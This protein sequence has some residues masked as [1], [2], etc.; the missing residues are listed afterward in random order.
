ME[1]LFS[2]DLLSIWLSWK[3]LIKM[4]VFLL[5][6]AADSF[7][8]IFSHLV[9]SQ[10]EEEEDQVMTRPP[11]CSP[12][13]CPHRS[14]SPRSHMCAKTPVPPTPFTTTSWKTWRSST[15][16]KS[17][18]V[19]SKW[20]L[21]LHPLSLF[22]CSS[23]ALRQSTSFSL[24]CKNPIFKHVINLKLKSNIRLLMFL[25]QVAAGVR[26]HHVL[27]LQQLFCWLFERDHHNSGWGRLHR[28]ER[29]PEMVRTARAHW[30]C[31]SVFPSLKRFLS[32]T[33]CF[34]GIW[35]HPSL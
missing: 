14:P 7:I 34:V 31:S 6:W 13:V 3:S 20:N 11:Q 8:L 5:A 2:F 1:H 22:L 17:V 16:G 27:P 32:F 26:E 30:W 24:V 35:L 28:G 23:E 19:F 29:K 18:R 33:L 21:T 15:H 10:Q 4:L 12:P 25:H 9:C